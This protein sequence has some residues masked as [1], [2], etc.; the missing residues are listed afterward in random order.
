MIANSHVVVT[1][2]AGFIGS[3]LLEELSKDKLLALFSIDDYSAGSELNHV[4]G[5]TYIRGHTKNISKLLTF[6]PAV[7]YHLGEYSR[8]TS[9]FQHPEFVWEQNCLGT[10]KVVE[11][12]H[13]NK[14]R[15]VYAA[16]STKMADGGNGKNQSPYAWCKATNVDLIN[17][18]GDWFGLD[19]VIVYF[20]NVY[21]DRKVLAK[22]YFTLVDIWKDCVQKN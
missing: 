4:P 3:H 19:F 13:Q 9:S 21:G 15:L 10:F 12:C 17:R 16:S 20:Y 6:T 1:G 5:V 8:V 14:V 7:I 2:G 22:E 11:Y 18:Y